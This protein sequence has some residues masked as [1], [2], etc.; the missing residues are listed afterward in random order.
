MHAVT[1]YA[2]RF[3][4]RVWS[5]SSFYRVLKQFNTDETILAKK[6]NRR[7]VTEIAALTYDPPC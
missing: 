1:L 2:Q 3:P 5:S 7:R 6:K 4:E